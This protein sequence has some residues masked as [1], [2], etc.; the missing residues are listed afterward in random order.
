[1]QVAA[2]KL[3]TNSDYLKFFRSRL[4]DLGAETSLKY[5]RAISELDCFITGHRLSLADISD[6]MVSDWAAQL[7]RQGLTRN[8]VI[9]YLNIL[10]SLLNSAIKKGLISPSCSPRILVKQLS[11]PE[12]GSQRLITD[13]TFNNILQTL[14]GAWNPSDN[15]NTFKDIF[16]FS[17]LN[18]AISFKEIALLKKRDTANY[19][20]ASR[21]IIERNQSAKRDY[22]FDL[23]QS[24]KTTAQIYSDIAN[25]LESALRGNISIKNL[26]V[27]MLNGSMWAAFAMKCGATAS[28]A[29]GCV[30]RVAPYAIPQFCKPVE[31]TPENKTRWIK[32][33]S[34]MLM[35]DMP[36]WY[37]M[38]LRKGTKFE[39]LKKEISETIKPAPE[40]FYPCETIR[41]QVGNKIVFKDHPFISNTVFFKIHPESV[42]SMFQ[43]IG[44]K[45]WCYRLTNT[46]D[47]P[48]AVIPQ[49]DMECFQ[50]AIGVFSPNM[51][52]HPIGELSPKPGEQVIVVKIGYENREG[53]IEEI[54]HNDCG[55]VIFRVKM[56]TDQGYEWRI[57]C[58]RRQIE[59]IL[60]N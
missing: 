26:D 15:Y 16:L 4:S 58:D 54:H 56:F 13:Q 24:Y 42:T 33:V 17:M 31:A 38:H 49:R 37:A 53:T 14:R 55:S 43:A 2:D 39:E 60:N 7:L 3:H 11:E 34:R 20:D 23:K 32:S 8:T 10:N 52:I 59:R 28:E 41:K 5:R 36:G 9:G 47:A 1:M 50:N 48:Y 51:K 27:D 30:G 6:M 40:L 12:V 57:D 44:S 19:D 21:I 35:D 18:G 45:A 25:G 22:V 46:P 29:L